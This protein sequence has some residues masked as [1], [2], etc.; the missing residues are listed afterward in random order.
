MGKQWQ[1]LFSWAPK[2]LQMVTTATKLKTLAPLKKSYDKPRQ[3]IK[4]QRHYFAHK[5]PYCQSYGFSSSHVWVWELDHKECLTP[6]NWC[7]WT[8]VLE[9]TL[10]SPLDCR[11]I[12]AVNPKGNQSWI[13][14]WRTD[15]ETETPVLWPPDSKNWLLRKDPDAGKD[16]RQEEKGTT[17]DGMVGD[18][19]GSMDMSLI[20][21]LELVMDREAWCAAVH[22]VTKSQTR[23]SDWTDLRR[24]RRQ[25]IPNLHPQ[26]PTLLEASICRSHVSALRDDAWGEGTASQS[27]WQYS[28]RFGNC[29]DSW[30]SERGT[31]FISVAWNY[32]C[33]HSEGT[34]LTVSQ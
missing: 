2:S 15:A 27:K 6:K 25:A 12:K 9:K 26:S 28:N 23:P 18:I 13:F 5:G 1:T 10:E 14:I 20:K 34:W 22:V 29:L 24:V 31:I 8:V 30:L 16:W 11:E 33:G 3:R 19:T 17:E 21:L 7:F 32:H 4:K